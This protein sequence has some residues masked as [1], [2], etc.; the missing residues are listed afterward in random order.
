[1][2][3]PNYGIIDW[4]TSLSEGISNNE[5]V[6]SGWGN[7]GLNWKDETTWDSKIQLDNVIESNDVY[8]IPAT[9]LNK[10]EFTLSFI[11]DI[12]DACKNPADYHIFFTYQAES[13]TQE[14]LIWYDF[15][16]G[17]LVFGW[18]GH[19]SL[20]NMPENGLC[21]F[22]VSRNNTIIELYLNGT[23]VLTLNSP[24][25]MLL[26]PDYIFLGG[27]NETGQFKTNC[28]VYNFIALD[29]YYTEQQLATMGDKTTGLQ[30]NE[31]C[32]F[33]APLLT[34]LKAY[35]VATQIPD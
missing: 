30:V 4:Q 34:D 33:A 7:D 26:Y 9:S 12:N 3:K 14:F 11:A 1:M 16:T 21:L 28:D 20:I 35:T 6:I 27:F 29:K 15:Y 23:K 25:Q 18:N 2:F 8:S 22:T 31:E 5:T 19:N 24:S 13:G 32:T 17:K 10:S